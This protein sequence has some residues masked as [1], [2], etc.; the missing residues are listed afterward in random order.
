MLKG[1]NLKEFLS[2]FKEWHA[3]V[4]GVCETVCPGEPRYPKMSDE[5]KEQIETESHYYRFGR[6]IGYISRVLFIAGV[7]IGMAAG[8]MAVIFWILPLLLRQ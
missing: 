8:I 5:L 1:I 3:L 6:V 7:V 2:D 4:F